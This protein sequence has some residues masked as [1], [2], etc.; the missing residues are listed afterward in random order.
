[1]NWTMCQNSSKPGKQDLYI[2]VSIYETI[3]ELGYL[4][5]VN[6]YINTGKSQSQFH[7]LNEINSMSDSPKLGEHLLETQM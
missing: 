5:K 4:F 1:M 6:L 7:S 2:S 3:L